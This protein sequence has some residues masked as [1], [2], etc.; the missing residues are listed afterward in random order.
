M[1]GPVMGQILEEMVVLNSYSKRIKSNRGG[2]GQRQKQF[3]FK[4]KKKIFHK[5]PLQEYSSLS[6]PT[7]SQHSPSWGDFGPFALL[8]S[9]RKSSRSA[10]GSLGLATS[11]LL[12]LRNR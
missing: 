6:K 12:L 3:V 10:S 4:K 7:S 5:S 1:R 11:L 2:G 8:R 9:S